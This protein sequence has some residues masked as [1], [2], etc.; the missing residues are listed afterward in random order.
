MG[1]RNRLAAATTALV[2]AA[3]LA[4]CSTP[5]RTPEDAASPSADAAAPSETESQGWNR[6]DLSFAEEMGDQAAGSVELAVAALT[7]A[8]LPQGAEELAVQIR[9]EQGPQA[10][11]LAQL[12]EGW[13]GEEGGSGANGTEDRDEAGGTSASG[14][15]EDGAASGAASE[16]DLDAMRDTAFDS[17]LQVLKAATGTDAARLFLQGMIARHQA[18]IELAD[19]E[20]QLG[21]ST[22][23][24]DLAGAMSAAQGEQLT[25]MRALLASYGG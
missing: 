22:E 15:S 13:S 5:P 24:L 25:K 7:V 20:A 12:A 8:D 11:E 10:E 21:T 9:D 1:Y 14:G 3:A 6:A 4:G 2:L 19:G 23:A 18:A 16:A 17:E